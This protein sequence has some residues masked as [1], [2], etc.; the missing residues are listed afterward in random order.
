MQSKLSD[1]TFHKGK[2]ITSLN[3]LMTGMSD[4][5]SWTYGRLPEYLWIGLVFNK[6]QRE[7]GLAKMQ[8]IIDVL[9][10]EL[11][12]L[13]APLLSDIISQSNETQ[14]KI[15]DQIKQII[16]KDTLAPLTIL[17]SVNEYPEF[18]KAF[19]CNDM[20]VDKREEILLTVMRLLMNHQSNESTDVR[21][22]VLS[23]ELKS[24]RLK[25]PKEQMEMMK[26][27]SVNE[28]SDDYMRVLRPF[29]RS[30]ELMTLHFEERNKEFLEFFWDGISKITDCSLLGMKFPE[31]D[32]DAS[33][34]LG[35]IY[36]SLSYLTELYKTL[37]PLDEKMQVLLGISTY[38]Y[39]R[40]KE[41]CDHSL[42]NS[43]AGRSCVRVLIENY[44]MMK[45]LLKNEN[46]HD[47]IWK[48]Y[49]FYGIGQYKLV[50][51]RL[52][53]LSTDEDVHYDEKYIEALVNE[54]VIEDS[55]DM[56]TKYFDKTNIRAKA[57]AVNEKK[58]YGL[59]YDY[60]SAYEH[61]LWGA[62]REST[63][64][65]C[66]NPAHQYHCVPDIDC[67]N[68]LKTVF[69]NCVMIMNKTIGMLDDI[70]GIPDG[71]VNEVKNFE[72]ES[73]D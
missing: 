32:K 38:S 12:N 8:K 50:L 66:N 37:R 49:Q 24:N 68:T 64:L 22:M 57:E 71:L 55:L 31:E 48:D 65:K 46:A 43:I 19:Y 17:L 28:H 10:A 27:Y 35:L 7:D 26:A 20:D 34:Y 39:K 23:L 73:F 25:I 3:E 61:G 62:I 72:A 18:A 16:S 69:P 6:Y 51:E 70:Y 2:F 11:P 15:Y 63:M 42:F 41:I 29:V 21:F 54:F 4:E 1:H 67:D 36:E 14:I 53:E 45:Y 30:A 52:R 13:F 33:N 47:N 44:I 56:D 40:F 5:E 60:D 58:L 59:Y 9:H